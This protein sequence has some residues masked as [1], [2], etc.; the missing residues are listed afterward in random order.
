MI[1]SKSQIDSFPVWLKTIKPGGTG[2]GGR[3]HERWKT[4]GTYSIENY[5]KD[6]NG[7]ILVDKIIR[8]EDIDRDLLPTLK[9]I[10]IPNPEQLDIPKINTN[11]NKIQAYVQ[12]YNDETRKYVEEL[13][14]YDIANFNYVFGE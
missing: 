6:D 3:E 5:I 7:N 14:Q 13:Y 10:G 1:K 8:L 12:Y 9:S 4:Y 2:G 11:K